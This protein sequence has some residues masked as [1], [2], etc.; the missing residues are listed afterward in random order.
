MP[1][2]LTQLLAVVVASS[3]LFP[4]TAEPSNPLECTILGTPGADYLRGTPGD[5]VICGLEGNDVQ[6]GRDGNDVLIGGPGRDILVGGPGNDELFGDD[7][8]D[9]LLDTEGIG[10]ENGGD[11]TDHCIGI[12]GTAFVRC[13]RVITLPYQEWERAA[14]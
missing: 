10:F 7:G 4:V 1:A 11:G 5:D 2:P 3:G 14:G 8:N 13:E 12:G 9:V 6:L